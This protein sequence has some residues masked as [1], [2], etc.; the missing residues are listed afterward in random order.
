MP[1]DAQ[2]AIRQVVVDLGR[3]TLMLYASTPSDGET[4]VTSQDLGVVDMGT[5]GRLIGIELGL[6]YFAVALVDGS[7]DNLIRSIEVTVDVNRSSGG[8]IQSIEI[9]R[10]GSNHEI[11]FPIGNQCWRQTINGEMVESCVVTVSREI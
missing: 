10:L 2:I 9:P 1:K 8:S 7:S 3:N 6:D 5:R 4:G 11:T